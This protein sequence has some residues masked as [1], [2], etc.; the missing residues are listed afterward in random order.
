MWWR[1]YYQTLFLEIKIQKISETIVKSH[2]QFVYIVC[3][4][5]SCQNILKLSC[6]P[7]AFTS[8]KTFLKNKKRPRTSLPTSFYFINWLNFI[9]WLPLIRGLLGNMCIVIVCQPGFDVI[10][11]ETNLIFLIRPFF[12]HD[13]KVKTKCD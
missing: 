10:N 9:V 8:Y 3:Q 7:L 6:R 2:M 11:F 4:F 13:Q 5:E 1:N 12:L